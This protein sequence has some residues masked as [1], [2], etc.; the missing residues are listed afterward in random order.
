MLTFI[1]TIRHPGHSE[2]Y[3][4]VW[5][6]LADTLETLR[7]QTDPNIQV[8]VVC[9]RA[10]D[11]PTDPR[12]KVIELDWPPVDPRIALTEF[13]TRFAI[14]DKGTKYPIAIAAALE[15]G[16][17]H[18]MF[19]DSDDFVARDLAEA[20][21]SEP[22]AAGWFIDR[23]YI[24]TPKAFTPFDDFHMRCGSSNIV[25]ADLLGACIPPGLDS[26]WQPEFIR[27]TLDRHVMLDV[28][29]N[30]KNH[31][32]YFGS[33]G[34]TIVPFPTRAAAWN[35]GTGENV[36]DI[37]SDSANLMTSQPDHAVL[38]DANR[39]RFTIP[40]HRRPEARAEQLPDEIKVAPTDPDDAGEAAETEPV[41]DLT[42][43]TFVVGMNKT[44]TSTMKGCFE[45][46]GWTP[47]AS[48]KTL[49]ATSRMFTAITEG[50]DYEFALSAVPQFM[51]FE[52]RP[53]NV[54]EFYQH[55]AHRYPSSRFILTRREPASWW[56]SV[57]NWLTVKKPGMVEIYT[58][59]LRAETFTKH[60]FIS[61]YERHNDE[62][63]RFFEGTG[64][65]LTVDVTANGRWDEICE[66]LGV[67]VPAEP[68]PHR[69]RQKYAA[70]PESPT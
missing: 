15:L 28:F 21:N 63:E 68:F 43:R 9:D 52:D 17:D 60:D 8:V 27:S 24:L 70:R 62:I 55:A 16:T 67:P 46:L 53:W 69:N 38:S 35:L 23:G 37:R 49:A 11:L 36:S 48:P 5:G 1:T 20:V 59:H 31:A 65:L 2:S 12:V 22:A 45:V 50:G 3:D 6:L 42:P 64:R 39:V 58:T 13:E 34:H 32:G 54:W 61:A 29:G 26:S 18:I 51:A 25:R 44:G 40:D 56:Q 47:V 66:F 19:V 7:A 4:R 41:R 30:H 57:E 33:M 14:L 10:L